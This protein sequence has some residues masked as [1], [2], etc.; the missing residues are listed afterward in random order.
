MF[1]FTNFEQTKIKAT[2]LVV[3]TDF[4]HFESDSYSIGNEDHQN[5][6]QGA[7]Q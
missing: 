7:A 6:H 1:A 5:S 3:L 2:I 4:R